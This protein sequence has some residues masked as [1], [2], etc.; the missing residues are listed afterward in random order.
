[1]GGAGGPK[2]QANGAF[3]VKDKCHHLFFKKLATTEKNRR[4]GARV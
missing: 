1:M 4:R 3:L 2:S